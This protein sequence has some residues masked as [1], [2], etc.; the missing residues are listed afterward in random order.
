[1]KQNKIEYLPIIALKYIRL[2]F[3]I[4]RVPLRELLGKVTQT[5]KSLELYYVKI[6]SDSLYSL[7]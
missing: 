4:P 3:K 7:K 5:L 1:M 6:N 2:T